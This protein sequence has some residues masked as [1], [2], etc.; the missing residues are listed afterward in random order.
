MMTN[1]ETELTFDEL[2]NYAKLFSGLLPEDEI[3][4]KSI[5]PIITPHLNAI[6]DSFYAQLN[7]IPQAASFLDGRIDILKPIHLNWLNLLFTQN[8]N[9]EFVKMMHKTGDTHSKVQL[10]IEFMI[11]AMTLIT[12]D[13]IKLVFT[14]FSDNP[15]Q[16]LKAIKAINA[17]TGFSLNLMLYSFHALTVA[18][19]TV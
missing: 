14:L 1:L 15:E 11:G 4:I 5:A 7:N 8:I 13:L 19:K 10:P 6:T 3:C 12:N 9:V 16:C 17:I 18:N 2:L